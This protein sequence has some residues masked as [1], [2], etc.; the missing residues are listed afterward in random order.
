MLSCGCGSGN[1]KLSKTRL[2]KT[3]QSEKFVGK[4]LGTLLKNGLPL[5]KN[6]L[7]PLAKI[8]LIAPRLTAAALAD[9]AIHK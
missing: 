1:T 6:A 2:H 8:V 4:L 5:I 7:K 3:G 9:A